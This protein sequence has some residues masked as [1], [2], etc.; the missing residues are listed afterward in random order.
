VQIFDRK[1]RLFGII[2]PIDLLVVVALIVAGLVAWKLLWGGSN[3]AVPVAQLKDVEYT[4][5]C[6]PIRNY[7]QGMVRVGDPVSTKTSGAT[8]GTVVS[9]ESSPTPGDVFN[10]KTGQIQGYHSTFFTDVYIRVK[11]KGDPT[12]TGVS[13]GNTQIRNNELIQAVTPTF[14]C[15]TAIVTALK[16]DGE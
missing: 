6:S 16:F 10:Q 15:D 12:S 9:I 3:T 11:A 1:Y 14:Q 5:M 2:N 8:I 7:S 4:I 13:V